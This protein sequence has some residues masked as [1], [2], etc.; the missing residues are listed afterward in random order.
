MLVIWN[1]YVYIYSR[2]SMIDFVIIPEEM[3]LLPKGV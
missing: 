3:K 2:N 1:M